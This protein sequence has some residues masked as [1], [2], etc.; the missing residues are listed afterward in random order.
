MDRNLV[1]W[2]EQKVWNEL[3]REKARTLKNFF[4]RLPVKIVTDV[5]ELDHVPKS[6]GPEDYT[7]AYFDSDEGRRDFKALVDR[8]VGEIIAE[9][10]QENK[11]LHELRKRQEEEKEGLSKKL[12]AMG[13]E[14][15]KMHAEIKELEHFETY[16]RLK[17]PHQ[18]KSYIYHLAANSD[19]AP[20]AK[21]TLRELAMKRGLKFDMKLYNSYM[22]A[23]TRRKLGKATEE[24][25]SNLQKRRVGP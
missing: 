6:Y 14:L 19:G 22:K 16:I 21:E 8:K 17:H 9:I 13:A 7:P 15:R 10:W 11:T 24:K 20:S 5:D 23:K 3:L 2:L 1:E 18:F 12:E 4:G 25:V